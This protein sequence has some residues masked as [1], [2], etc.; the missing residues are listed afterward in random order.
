MTRERTMA[1]PDNAPL[2]LRPMRFAPSGSRPFQIKT[3]F[4]NNLTLSGNYHHTF[5][6]PR[7]I[8]LAVERRVFATWRNM[9]SSLFVSTPSA[10][11]TAWVIGSDR[12]SSRDGSR[13]HFMG[14]TRFY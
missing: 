5:H 2:H 9:A 13:Q 6:P 12:M 3:G 7:P 1:S 11:M 4:E 8:V 10:L 14:V